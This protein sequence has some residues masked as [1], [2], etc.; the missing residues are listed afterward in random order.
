MSRSV[1]LTGA[2]GFVGKN[3]LSIYPQTID[4]VLEVNEKEF[5]LT[6]TGKSL[7]ESRFI[8]SDLKQNIPKEITHVL[9]FGANTSTLSSNIESFSNLNIKA[10]NDLVTIS[11][12][13][14]INLVIASSASVYG[15]SNLM[16]ENQNLLRPKN[17]YAASKWDSEEYVKNFCK[18]SEPHITILRLFN[19]YG[20]NEMHKGAMTSIVSRFINDA[21][22]ENSISIF[23]RDNL[24]IGS[25]S[26][27]M[28]FVRD[29]CNFIFEHMLGESAFGLLNFGTGISTSFLEISSY[30][31]SH[32]DNLRIEGSVMPAGYISNYQWFTRSDTTIFKSIFPEFRFTSVAEG[33]SELLNQNAN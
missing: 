22:N 25:Q 8:F 5:I 15:N 19:L 31:T 7:L 13:R 23:T 28:V 18:C 24:P 21:K 12:E 33:I 29:L 11:C 27:D 26:R 20:N 17:L 6:N 4:F 9:H 1:L 2:S 32:F 16:S 30:L 3:F 14:K 10:T